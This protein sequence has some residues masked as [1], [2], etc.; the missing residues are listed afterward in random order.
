VLGHV[1]RDRRVLAFP[2]RRRVGWAVQEQRRDVDRG[3][4]GADVDIEVHAAQGQE[5]AG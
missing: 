5:R 1:R 2:L 3:K 4:H